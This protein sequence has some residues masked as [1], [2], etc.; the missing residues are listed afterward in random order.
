MNMLRWFRR[1]PPVQKPPLGDSVRS[2]LGHVIYGIEPPVTT[3]EFEWLYEEVLD[4]EVHGRRD[5]SEIIENFIKQ[6]NISKH[7]C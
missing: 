5:A 1:K 2:A 6:R 4:S 7:A 3:E